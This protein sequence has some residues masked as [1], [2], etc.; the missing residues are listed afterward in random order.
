MSQDASPGFLAGTAFDLLS[1]HGGDSA[2]TGF[3]V[4]FG[5]VRGDVVASL[6]TGQDLMGFDKW[7]VVP[8]DPRTPWVRPLAIHT[9]RLNQAPGQTAPTDALVVRDYGMFL[10]NNI[11]NQPTQGIT[12][13][14]CP[15]QH[16]RFEIKMNP[17]HRGPIASTSCLLPHFQVESAN[18]LRQ[19]LRCKLPVDKQSGRN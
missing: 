7:I 12:S 16:G 6:L 3:A 1:D 2:E 13:W 4:G 5:G 14:I 9:R 18:F 11:N 8:I 10:E 17:G 15:L 19:A